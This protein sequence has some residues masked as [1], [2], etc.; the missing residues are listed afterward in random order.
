MDLENDEEV[1]TNVVAKKETN[2]D[3][4]RIHENLLAL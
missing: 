2:L 3:S 1:R 4:L